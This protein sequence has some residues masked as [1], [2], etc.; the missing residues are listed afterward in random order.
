MILE[1]E[2][3]FKI[4]MLNQKQKDVF[5]VFDW[6]KQTVKT[7]P[8]ISESAIDPLYIFLTGNSGCRKLFLT[9]KYFDLSTEFIVISLYLFCN[10]KFLCTPLDKNL[11]FTR[12]QVILL[13]K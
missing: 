8:S 2:F 13:K 6:S 10:E 9:K 4:K 1:E 3:D 7:L 11:L 5:D 12:N